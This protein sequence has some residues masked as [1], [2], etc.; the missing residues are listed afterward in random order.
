MST[1]PTLLS[2]RSLIRLT[3]PDT[4][5]L[6]DSLLT[7]QV[8]DIEEGTAGYGALLTPQG[9]VIS[10]MILYNQMGDI[11]LETADD[12]AEGVLRRLMMYKLRAD[13]SIEFETG[14][15][16]AHAREPLEESILAVADPR[17]SVLGYRCLVPKDMKLADN[18]ESYDKTRFELG[19][20]EGDEIE[21]EK[22]FW[23]ET[24]AETHNGVSFSKGCYVGQELTARMKHRTSVKKMIV[25][26]SA[27]APLDPGAEIIAEDGRVAGSVRA[28][29]GSKGLAS[30]RLERA[31]GPLTVSEQPI[32]LT[33]PPNQ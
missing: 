21:R 7:Q 8:S 20:P 32:Q 19:I 1:E 6:L 31:S 24:G 14:L 18:R 23:L 15:K 13:V 33:L 12:E 22:D 11:L 16:V 3:G 10:A 5:T 17:S 2:N 27:S 4:I 30:V 9:K 29:A 25:P 28:F 26:L